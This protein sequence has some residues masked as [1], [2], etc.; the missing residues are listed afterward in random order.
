MTENKDAETTPKKKVRKNASDRKKTAP[1]KKKV[2]EKPA[3]LI[4]SNNTEEKSFLVD[5]AET[6]ETGAKIVGEK[7]T[8]IAS[9]LAQKT[10]QVARTIFNKVKKDLTEVYEA[11]SKVVAGAT[12][13]AQDYTEKY[14]NKVEV[15]ELIKERQALYIELGSVIYEK[16][17]SGGASFT[18]LFKEKDVKELLRTIKTKENEIVKMG[19]ELGE[20]EK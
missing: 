2:P 4:T 14:K 17:K 1:V 19:Q 13:V 7:T 3:P 12:E 9:D 16:N 6:I 11:G 5:T 20:S 15:K 8:E 10:A 18:Q